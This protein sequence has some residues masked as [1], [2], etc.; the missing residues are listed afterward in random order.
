MYFDNIAN[1]ELQMFHRVLVPN[2]TITLTDLLTSDLFRKET[3]IA[4]SIYRIY[5]LFYCNEITSTNP[6]DKILDTQCLICRKTGDETY[7]T[8]KTDDGDVIDYTDY[9]SYFDIGDTMTTAEY[10]ALVSLLKHNITHNEPV[11]IAETVTG[12]YGVYEFDIDGTTILDNGIMISEETLFTQPKVRLTNPFFHWGR[13]TLKLS[14]LH[15]ES[16]GVES[17]GNSTI[18]PV[19]IELEKDTWVDIPVTDME[20]GDIILFTSNVKITHDKAELHG[21]NGLRAS[22][23]KE[24]IKSAEQSEIYGHL[25]DYD[26]DPWRE[27]GKTIHFFEKLEPV[28]TGTVET[29]YITIN[30]NE[31]IYAKLVDEDGSAVGGETIHFFEAIT[32]MLLKIHPSK[33]VIQ[34]GDNNEIYGR[35]SDT[36]GSAIAGETVH[37]FEKIED[38]T[39]RGKVEEQVITTSDTNEV[40]CKVSDIDGSGIPDETVHF[41]AIDNE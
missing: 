14:V 21:L 16:V 17:A 41:F 29:Q 28:I 15:Y 20:N 9:A 26:G 34:T 40:Y 12:E 1:R 3:I 31:E 7:I 10:N 11:S 18:T 5:P 4:D 27:A 32:E 38:K 8:F 35:V 2:F 39:L 37:F 19:E 36:D 23:S 13:Y 24:I 33:R 6:D 25:L 30:N 22:T